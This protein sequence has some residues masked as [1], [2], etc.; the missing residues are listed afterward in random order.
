MDDKQ[1]IKELEEQVKHLQQLIIKD[2]LTGALNRK[3]I[4][5]QLEGIF[6]Q[7]LWAKEHPD[8]E[9]ENRIENL[10][11]LF[12]DIDD[13]KKVND[14]YGH[15]AGDKVL[16]GVA[17]VIKEE[18]R[19]LDLLG[20]LGG[21][22]FVIALLYASEDVAFKKAEDIRKTVESTNFLPEVEGFKV[23]LSIGVASV[24]KTNA[25][26]VMELIEMADK[27]M[28]EAKKNR[29]KNN[30]VKFSE[31]ADKVDELTAQEESDTG[32]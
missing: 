7:A 17:H 5:E 1:K 10:S 2:E 4:L 8:A 15:D 26:E 19:D 12:M 31:I 28:Y 18:V 27:A 13:F 3:G 25:D 16:K 30:T 14:T 29:G 20:R 11:T 32:R 24:R 21:E 22:E 23:T 6:E 9:R